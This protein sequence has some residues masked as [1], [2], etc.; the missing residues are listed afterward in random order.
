MAMTPLGMRLHIGIFGI[1]NA[2]KSSLMNSLLGKQVSI[3]SPE[4]GTTAD[5]VKGS[6]HIEGINPAL[7]IDTAGIDDSGDLGLLRSK[8]AEKV[9]ESIDLALLVVSANQ[10]DEDEK[11]ILHRFKSIG[12]PVII[13]INKID[14]TPPTDEYLKLLDNFKYPV[15]LVS[16][17]S[18]SGIDNL[19]EVILEN[20][21]EK[22]INSPPMLSD[23]V[24][25][26]DIAAQVMPIDIEAPMG[27]ILLPQAQAV[28][29]VIDC[30]G[31]SIISKETELKEALS[32]LKEPPE[33]VVTDSQAFKLVSELTP[34]NSRL[35]SYSTLFARHKGDLPSFVAGVRGV[36]TLKDGDL[37]LVAE[38]CIHHPIGN[39]IGRIQ[40]PKKLQDYTGKK[41]NFEFMQGKDFPEDLKHYKMIIHCGSC[42]FN[43]RQLLHRIMKAE[44]QGVFITNYG[45]LLA[46]LSGVLNRAITPFAKTSPRIKDYLSSQNTNQGS[47]NE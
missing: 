19:K 26:A 17:L 40:I 15:V 7:L 28:R 44:Q 45:V 8:T 42:M 22:W 12:I 31:V 6:L 29:E 43:R 25:K 14:L 33:L 47:S 2:G 11:T 20:I 21:P 38:A 30:E 5:P 16:A 18:G 34:K 35:T 9:L 27:R 41:L 4:P 46:Y 3:V 10:L 23:L 13:V 24:K 32:F 36:D 1:R 37:I 39:D